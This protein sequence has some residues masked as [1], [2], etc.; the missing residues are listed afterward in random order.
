MVTE[1]LD[2]GKQPIKPGCLIVYPAMVAQSP[3]LRFAVVTR[4][5]RYTKWSSNRPTLRVIAATETAETMPGYVPRE[6]VLQY[7]DRVFVVEKFNVPVRTREWL[8][9]AYNRFVEG[10]LEKTARSARPA[11]D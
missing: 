4:L 10:V 5:E 3:V 6:T 2:F 7:P 1:H 9:A 11:G 8:V